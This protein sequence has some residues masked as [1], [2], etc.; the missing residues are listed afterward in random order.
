MV[1]AA[2]GSC[3]VCGKKFPHR[4]GRGRPGKFCGDECREKHHRNRMRALQNGKLEYDSCRCGKEKLTTS[5]VCIDC[6]YE[7]HSKINRDLLEKLYNRGAGATQLAKLFGV[8]NQ[9]VYYAVRKLGL[10][11]HNVGGRSPFSQEEL[12][13]LAKELA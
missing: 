4:A 12:E 5:H 2:N 9:A 6:W 7:N 1:K 8:H 3:L 13:Q 10:K 11:K